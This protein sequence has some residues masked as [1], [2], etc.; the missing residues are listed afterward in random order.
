MVQV[1][2]RQALGAVAGTPSS[3]ITGMAFSLELEA[4]LVCLSTGELLQ[5]TVGQQQ[6]L[7]EMGS[8]DGGL[9][10]LACSPDGEVFVAVSGTGNL[11]LMNQVLCQALRRMHA[12]SGAM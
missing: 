8:V 7:T 12:H 5:L 6:E 11:L 4:L 3:T 9:F 1:L 10:A 2:W